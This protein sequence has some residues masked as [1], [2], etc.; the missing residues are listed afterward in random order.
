[1]SNAKRLRD[2]AAKC[3]ELAATASTDA[4]RVRQEGLAETYRRM[5]KRED[6]LDAQ[7][8]PFAQEGHGGAKDS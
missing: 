5:A 7:V 1:M 2:L 3:D 6:W 4:M 8:S